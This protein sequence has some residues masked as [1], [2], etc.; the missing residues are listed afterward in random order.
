MRGDDRAFY[1]TKSP[2]KHALY[3]LILAVLGHSRCQHQHW[4]ADNDAAIS[5]L[6][7]EKNCLHKAYVT[8]LTDDNKAAV[9]RSRRL[10]QQRQCETQDARKA[11]EIQG[12]ADRNEWKNF[13]ATKAVYRPPTKATS[14]LLS[15]DSSTLQILQRW[16]EHFR[17]VLNRPSIISDAAFAH[18]TPIETNVDL[19]LLPSLQETSRAVQ[20]LSSGKA[21]GSDAIPAEV[22]KHGGS[23]LMDSLTALSQEMWRQA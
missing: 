3:K 14:P 20:K 8:G 7:A 6:P 10:V 15:A 1:P 12:Y 11:E 22:Y 13:S 23:Q 17:G 5:N 9:Y 19:D 4:F 18:L 21:P 2:P 16:T